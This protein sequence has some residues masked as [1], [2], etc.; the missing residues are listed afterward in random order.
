MRRAGLHRVSDRVALGIRARDR[1]IDGLPVRDCERRV[2]CAANNRTRICQPDVDCVIGKSAVAV[3]D[4]KHK[5]IRANEIASRKGISARRR[6]ERKPAMRRAGLHR[7]A[8]CVAVGVG[9]DD[10]AA[11]NTVMGETE[12]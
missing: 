3:A 7:V 9:R 5:A 10:S 8:E 11:C 6:I 4:A 2:R 12:R 1:T